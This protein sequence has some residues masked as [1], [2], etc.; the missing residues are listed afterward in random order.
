VLFSSSAGV[1]GN[2]GQ[3][4]YAAANAFLDALAAH[5]HSLGLPARSLAWGL[6][7]GEHG[8]AGEL[9][10]DDRRRM[11]RSG[12][13]PLSAEEG[14]A[15]FDTAVAADQPALVPIRL[16]L[17][18][19]AQA[20][21]LPPLLSGLVRGSGGRA[22]AHAHGEPLLTR[23]LD[24]TAQQRE[25]AL[26]DMIRTHA[27]ATLGHAGPEHIPAERAFQ[28]LGFD[29]LSAVELRNLLNADTG[30]RLPPTLVF[31]YPNPAAL[32]AELAARLTPGAADGQADTEQRIRDV[33]HTIPLSR[34]RDA[35]LLERLLELG[36]AAA[37]ELLPSEGGG[38]TPSI[39]D[40]DADA[41]INMALGG[42]DDPDSTGTMSG[43]PR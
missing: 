15:L 33:L 29:S 10:D 1:F 41:L 23:L 16:D 6:W 20:A 43:E 30:M 32:A 11:S 14:L 12:V 19:L 5:R 26:I 34:L 38:D 9:G 22:G 42:G 17:P 18:S 7:D 31:D 37:L 40:M 8:M 24:M 3:G 36:G 28:E 39:D 35:G 2:P 25:T 13:R 4:S 27:A 21:A